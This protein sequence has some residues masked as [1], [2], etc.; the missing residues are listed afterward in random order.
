MFPDTPHEV[1]V[2]QSDLAHATPFYQMPLS[3]QA[4]PV[5]ERPAVVWVPDAYGRMVPM[6]KD[7]I[8][9]MQ[10][11]TPQQVTPQP[12]LLDPRAQRIAAGGLL[13]AGAGWGVGQ[14]LNAFAGIGSGALMWL[15]IAIVATKLAPAMARTTTIT[16]TTNVT[17]YNRWFGKSASEITNNR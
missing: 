1:A 12:P 4:G 6:P 7:P 16:N 3:Y 5:D 13:A 8:T 17:S 2:I 15:A 11:I 10:P 14:V 9:A